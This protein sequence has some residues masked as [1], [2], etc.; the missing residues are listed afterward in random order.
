MALLSFY[1]FRSN[2]TILLSGNTTEK[3]SIIQNNPSC[4]VMNAEECSYKELSF[5]YIVLFTDADTLQSLADKVAGYKQFLKKTGTLVLGFYNHFGTNILVGDL[6]GSTEKRIGHFSRKEIETL[7]NKNGFSN[8]KFYSVLPNLVFP[9][10]V[11]SEGY[12]INENIAGRYKPLYQTIETI[13]AD[14]KELFDYAVHQG[15][16]F[17]YSNAFLL[18]C[19]FDVPLS[20]V[21]YVTFSLE[22][23]ESSQFCTVIRGNSVEKKPL[24]ESG[25]ANINVLDSNIKYLKNRGIKTIDGHIENNTYIMPYV[26]AKTADIYLKGLLVDDKEEFIKQV[27]KFKELIYSSSEISGSGSAGPILKKAFIDFVPL[28]AFLIDNEFVF[29]DQEFC[30]DDYPANVILYR[31]LVILYE[32]VPEEKQTIPISFFFDRYGLND[33]LPQIEEI[34]KSFVGNLHKNEFNQE[35]NNFF[36]IDSTILE[37]NINKVI[38]NNPF[39]QAVNTCFA[40]IEDKK[41]FLFGA[42][43]FAKDFISKYKNKYDIVRILDNDCKKW[44]SSLDG[45]PIDSPDSLIGTQFGYKVIVCMKNYR[46]A[47]LQ[48][49]RMQV[50]YIGIYSPGSK[51]KTGYLSGVFDLYHI[52]HINMFRRAKEQCDYLIV[53]VTS[54]EYVL[55]KKKRTPFIPCDERI[56]VIKSCKYV[57]KVVKIPYMHEEITEAWEKYHYDVQFCGS[58][59]ENDPWWLEQKAWLQA[60]G[61]DL[62]F[63]PYTQQTSSTKIKSLID[64][65]LL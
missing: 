21:K 34:E 4:S 42:G 10:F 11:I 16:Y 6:L 35:R 31:T 39:N 53:G 13:I 64:K 36:S 24:F 63:F 27:D 5:D 47:Y 56:T 1:P 33:L 18:E 28:N 61:S 25:I 19:S 9:Q 3:E 55:N 40:N 58:D 46:A 38:D 45:I 51:Y 12:E 52:G 43:K 37:E 54:D 2:A 22:R 17:D 49:K 50:L 32:N 30:F 48:L 57:D 44:G 15:S 7:I 65:S 23:D 29:F 26:K 62:V 60:H 8:H 59:C 41:I 20:D 14:E